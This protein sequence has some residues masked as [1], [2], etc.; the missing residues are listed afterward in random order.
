MNATN[1]RRGRGRRRGCSGAT[2]LPRI[3]RAPTLSPC[4]RGKEP[5]AGRAGAEQGRWAAPPRACP[6]V[7]GEDRSGQEGRKKGRSHEAGERVRGKV[8]GITEPP[9]GAL[10][11]VQFLRLD[12]H[13]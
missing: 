13:P 7:S 3:V 1:R 12:W 8:K 5:R 2:A 10:L 9:G 11:S 4:S 6:C